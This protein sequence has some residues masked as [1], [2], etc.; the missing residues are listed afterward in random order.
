MEAACNIAGLPRLSQ[1]LL[2]ARPATIDRRRCLIRR[3]APTPVRLE[4]LLLADVLLLTHADRHFERER[5]WFWLSF[6]L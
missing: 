3:L 1:P 5:L 4:K 2:V 6:R